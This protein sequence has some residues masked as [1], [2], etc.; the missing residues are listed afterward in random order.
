L[1]FILFVLMAL[2]KIPIE[3]KAQTPK[4]YSDLFSYLDQTNQKVSVTSKKEWEIKR[5]QILYG[6]QKAMGT[7][8][9]TLNLSPMDIQ[10]RDSLKTD[11]YTRYL[12]S[13]TPAKNEEVTC[14]LYIPHQS[15]DIKRLPAVLALHPT[16]D[17]GKAI[18]DGQGPRPNRAYA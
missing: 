8:P 13:F 11:T 5:Q 9:D 12:I 17:L 14:Y 10:Y 6:M 2:I 18:V 1:T 7:F 3:G 4:T 15:N 16:G